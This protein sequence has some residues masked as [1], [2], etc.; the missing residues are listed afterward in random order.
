MGYF[1]MA[2]NEVKPV[3]LDVLER[4]YVVGAL[5]KQIQSVERAIKAASSE[6]MAKVLRD[7]LESLNFLKGKFHG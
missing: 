6:R 5:A 7:D 1:D 4:A 3:Q 2:T